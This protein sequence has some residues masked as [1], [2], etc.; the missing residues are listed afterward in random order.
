MVGSVAEVVD[1]TSSDGFL[2]CGWSR[3]FEFPSVLWDLLVTW[4]VM[5][6]YYIC[7]TAFFQNNLGKPIPQR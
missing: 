1:V 7:L 5:Y 6:Y 3:C 4:N 2:V